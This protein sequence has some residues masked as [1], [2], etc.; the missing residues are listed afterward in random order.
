MKVRRGNNWLGATAVAIAG[1]TLVVGCARTVAGSARVATDATG[2]GTAPSTEQ[3][4]DT[5]MSSFESTSGTTDKSG[6]TSDTADGTETVGSTEGSTTSASDGSPTESPVASSTAVPADDEALYPTG[7]RRLNEHPTSEISAGLLESRRLA[8]YVVYPG[9]VMP[10]YT[11]GKIPTRPLA[12]GGALSLVL[13]DPV[14]AVASRAGMYAGFASTR[15]SK[16]NV[17]ALVITVME[18]P[19]TAAA[20]KAAV[21]LAAAAKDDGDAKL[22]VPGIPKAIGWTRKKSD[23][24]F[25]SHAFLAQGSLVL[26]A[27]ASDEVPAHQAALPGIVGKT[28]TLQ[29]Q[30]LKGFVP[31]PKDKLMTLPV[32]PDGV[33]ART[34][35]P[36]AD[37]GDTVDGTYSAKGMLHY[38]GSLA[39]DGKVFADAGVDVVGSG[40][41]TVYRAKDNAGAT[42][43]RDAYY[44]EIH[45]QSPKMQDYAIPDQPGVKCLEDSLSASYYCTG[46]VGRYAFE[47]RSDSETDVMRSVVSQVAML[48]S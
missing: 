16:D 47:Y 4:S 15:A 13:T 21:D 46:A 8:D 1:I 31:T 42:L 27:F 19:T 3:T 14:P 7:P 43:I 23:K 37:K 12:D 44:N 32:D 35:P 11:D 24:G 30:A 34:L 6:T 26:Y 45:T 29:S 33:Y 28:F 40:R 36:A 38:M 9:T 17:G 22:T 39:N 41:S 20:A 48:E 10:L 18:F 2:L 25:Y 5:A